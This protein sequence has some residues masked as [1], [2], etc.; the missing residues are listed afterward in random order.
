[1]L[2]FFSARL[3]IQISFFGFLIMRFGIRVDMRFV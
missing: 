3:I 2:A 1:L